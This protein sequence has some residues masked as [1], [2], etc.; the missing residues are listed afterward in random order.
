MRPMRPGVWELS[1]SA[2]GTRHYRTVY[3]T[4]TEAAAALAVFAAEITGRFDNLETLIAAYLEH[5]EG[6]SRSI[7]TLRR[8]RQLWHQ[9]LSPSLASARP[10]QITRNQ[11]EHALRTMTHAGQSPSSIHQAAVLLSSCLAW[12]Q[13]QGYLTANP[14]FALRLPDGRTLAPPR[15]R[16]PG[17]MWPTARP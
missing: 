12:A 14:A 7:L 8:Y 4:D 13:R 3:G 9:W 6:E 16:G 10:D 15:R 1:A 5:L 2:G 11:L 17:V